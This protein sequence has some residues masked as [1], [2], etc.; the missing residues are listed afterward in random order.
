MPRFTQNAGSL[1]VNPGPQN[2]DF[3]RNGLRNGA[4]EAEVEIEE[5]DEDEE[6]EDDEFETEMMPLPAD[7]WETKLKRIN[8]LRKPTFVTKE[9]E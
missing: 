1:R 9:V 5:R 4:E 2:S 8:W 7:E 3:K 6:V